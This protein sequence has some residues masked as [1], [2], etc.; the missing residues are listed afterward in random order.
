MLNGLTIETHPAQVTAFATP[1]NARFL[2]LHD[3][4]NDDSIRTFFTETYELYLR[5]GEAKLTS[6]ERFAESVMF[7]VKCRSC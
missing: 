5:V 7:A 4:R 2:L 3:G 1:G 6:S